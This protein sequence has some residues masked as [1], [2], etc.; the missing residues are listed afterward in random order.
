MTLGFTIQHGF[1]FGI[2]GLSKKN[3]GSTSSFLG[4]YFSVAP[5]KDCS[6]SKNYMLFIRCVKINVTHAKGTFKIF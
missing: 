5:T 3:Q 4:S 6:Q 2:I 1:L